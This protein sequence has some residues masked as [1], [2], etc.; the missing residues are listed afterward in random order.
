MEGHRWCRTALAVDTGEREVFV[1]TG[2][3]VF[4]RVEVAIRGVPAS[5]ARLVGGVLLWGN[6]T[7]VA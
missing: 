5:D 1:D 3:M 2:M 4:P 7:G 6:N